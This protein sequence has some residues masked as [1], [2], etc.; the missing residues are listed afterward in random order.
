MH[1]L[2]KVTAGTVVDSAQLREAGIVKGRNDGLRVLGFGELNVALTVRA[3]HFSDSAREKI[4]AA[5]GTAEIIGK[6]VE[7]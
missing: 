5:G 7:A 2:N 1:Q 4:E 3:I 6:T